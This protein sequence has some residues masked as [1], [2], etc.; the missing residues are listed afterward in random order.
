MVL[1]MMGLRVFNGKR[2]L[3]GANV[4]GSFMRGNALDSQLALAILSPN[5]LVQDPDEAYHRAINKNT[6]RI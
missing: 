1:T 5:Y 4:K 6:R 3:A 2:D